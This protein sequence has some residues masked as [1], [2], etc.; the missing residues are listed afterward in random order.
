[1]AYFPVAK[2]DHQATIIYQAFHHKLT[3]KTPRSTTTISQNPLQKQHS[4][5]PQKKEETG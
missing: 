1:V 4:T 3:T 2:Y 5:T